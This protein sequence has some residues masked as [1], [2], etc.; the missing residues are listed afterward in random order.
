MTLHVTDMMIFCISNSKQQ[1]KEIFIPLM[2]SLIRR[3]IKNHVNLYQTEIS[4]RNKKS[5]I[6]IIEMTSQMLSFKCLCLSSM[7]SIK[8]KMKTLQF[9][10]T[11]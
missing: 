5:N 8:N 11:H 4:K 1:S 7:S 9:L 10:N 6:L 3:I 2:Y